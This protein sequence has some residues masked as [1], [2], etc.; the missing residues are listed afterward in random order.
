MLVVFYLLDFDFAGYL[1]LCFF[2]AICLW[3][4]WLILWCCCLV[5]F[6]AC[7]FACSPVWGALHFVVCICGHSWC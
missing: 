6:A 4:I 1:F 5:V 7:L 3:L 2:F